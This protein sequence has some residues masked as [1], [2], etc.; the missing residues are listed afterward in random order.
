MNNIELFEKINE[1]LLKIDEELG[2][3]INRRDKL[4]QTT[5]FL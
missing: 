2:L 3:T 5:I 4:E 1:I